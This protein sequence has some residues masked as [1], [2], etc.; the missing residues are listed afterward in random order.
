[1][2]AE[3]NRLL[4]NG[5]L[6]GI[7]RR[8]GQNTRFIDRRRLQHLLHAGGELFAVF[9]HR[10]GGTLFHLAG[11]QFN[12]VK[13]C[14]DVQ[15]KLLALDRAH[16]VVIFKRLLKYRADVG[17]NALQILLRL[18]D[19]QDV[20]KFGDRRG[21]D[22]FFQTE[23]TTDPAQRLMVC[24]GET[25]VHGDDRLIGAGGIDRHKDVDLAA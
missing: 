15:R 18:C 9:L 6:V 17:G 1:M 11:E 16:G 5:D 7:N 25:F 24:F 8:F 4:V 23:Q 20:G 13:A 19:G 2:G 3:P 21:A 14:A 22:L 12:G 10:F